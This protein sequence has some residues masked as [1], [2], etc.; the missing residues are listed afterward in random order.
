MA[1]EGSKP[2]S[3][4]GIIGEDG[5]H[6]VKRA[7]QSGAKFEISNV[8]ERV[9][10]EALGGAFVGDDLIL[11]NPAW[12]ARSCAHTA[13]FH[14]QLPCRVVTSTALCGEQWQ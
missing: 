5:R 12:L 4:S 2:E 8:H 14:F 10:D 1:H 11:A 6:L 9:G 3:L 7:P 13:R